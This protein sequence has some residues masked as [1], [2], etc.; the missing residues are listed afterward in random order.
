MTLANFP[1]DVDYAPG[2]VVRGKQVYLQDT[3]IPCPNRGIAHALGW[4][5][6]YA[7]LGYF[8]LAEKEENA[9]TTTGFA[10][11][12]EPGEILAGIDIPEDD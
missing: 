9:S 2:V 3:I 8:L 11:E 4:M 7:K 12:I 10:C 5:L 6:C 1:E